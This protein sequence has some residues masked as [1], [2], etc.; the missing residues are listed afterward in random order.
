[1]PKQSANATWIR[2]Q[3]F[4]KRIYLPTKPT[5]QR[6]NLEN[7]I[8]TEAIY[9]SISLGKPYFSF[10]L[11]VTCLKCHRHLHNHSVP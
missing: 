8:N 1:M 6:Y 9:S 5:A 10:A 4:I 7:L 11:N 2:K 3:L